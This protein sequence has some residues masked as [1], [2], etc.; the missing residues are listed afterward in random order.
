MCG[1]AGLLGASAV[2]RPAR[3]A[4]MTASIHHRGPDDSGAWSDSAAGITL[5]HRRLAIIDLSPAGHQPMVSDN[6]RWV[7]VYNGEIYNHRDLR[8]ALDDTG[9][10]PPWRGHSDSESLLAAVA[11]WGVDKALARAAG[12]FA[13]GI[14]DREKRELILARDRFGEKPLYYGRVGTDFAFA[15]ELKALRLLPDFAGE[16]DPAALRAMLGRGYVPADDSIYRGI[17]QVPPGCWLTVPSD[18][19]A[20]A[21]QA[22]YDYADVVA[23]G[24]ANP[25]SDEKEALSQ[26]R[27]TMGG[28]VERQLAADVPV[29]TLLSGGIDSSLVTALAV[30]R[31]RTQVRTFSIGFD[32]AG[33]DEAPHARAVAAHLGTA[34]H[35]LYVTA[36]DA[37]ALIPSLPTIWD[38]PFGDASQ[39]PTFLVS[40]YAREHVTVALSGDAGDELFGG[41]HRHRALP[42][43]ERRLRQVPA[44]LRR[45]AL[46][47]GAAVPPGWWTALAEWRSG[48]ARPA[49]FGHKIR[50]VLATARDAEDLGGLY[51]GFLDDWHGHPAPL[52]GDVTLGSTP[53]ADTA[54]LDATSRVM[55]A[56]ALSYLPGDIL[57]KVDRAAMAVS[58]EG[59]IPFLDP[60]VAALAARIPTRMKVANG[61]GKVILRRLLSE[62]APP[63]LFDRPKAGFAIPLGAWLSGPLREWSESLLEPSALAASGLLDHATIRA[64][65]TAHCAGRED[66]SQALWNVLMFQAWRQVG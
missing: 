41:Y 62:Y 31:S 15:S 50:R 25:I 53:F 49:F 5:G 23:E 48:T 63:A 21:P 45:T 39:I 47:A 34:H 14:W 2:A 36:A 40:R 13:L 9:Q 55:L 38:E 61:Q 46:S 35:E 37:L 11:A 32:E 42:A 20:G 24:A 10:A 6:G 7:M 58:L 29:G 17:A 65:W 56:D 28:A 27:Q 8:A 4:A 59:R 66:A 44:R 33:F 54:A 3:V 1:I 26:L 18:G 16:I 52:A 43:L 64:R 22:F 19:T 57:T 51:H 12:M 30:E 60:Q